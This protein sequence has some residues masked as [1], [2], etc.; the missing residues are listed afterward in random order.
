ML[1]GESLIMGTNIGIVI[2]PINWKRDETLATVSESLG[3]FMPDSTGV[4]VKI[5]AYADA[6]INL[7]QGVLICS[8]VDEDALSGPVF[9]HG[10]YHMWD[11]PLYYYNLRENAE[12][13]A[14]KFL[15]K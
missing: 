7:A 5:L 1:P 6:R 4:Y 15:A 2:N 3:S 10:G 9:G 14:N 8:S 12:R 11:Y 13:R